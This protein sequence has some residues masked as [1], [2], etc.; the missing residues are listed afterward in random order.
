MHELAVEEQ[1]LPDGEVLDEGEV[2]VHRLDAG[3][4]RVLRRPE[5]TV[6]PSKAIGPRPGGGCR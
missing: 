1:V 2:L 5:C 4:A 3:L 6:C